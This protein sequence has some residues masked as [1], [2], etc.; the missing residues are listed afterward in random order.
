MTQKKLRADQLL[1]RLGEVANLDQAKRFIMAGQVYTDK[2]EPVLTAGQT[3]PKEAVL[4]IKKKEKKYVSRGGY[5]LEKAIEVFNL[6][7][8]DKIALDIGSSTGGFT[9][10]FLQNGAKLV[11][12]LDVGTNQLDWK[13]RSDDR[14]IVMEQTNFRFVEKES[15]T[16]GLPQLV[17][18][19][20]SFISLDLIFPNL[21]TII[22]E[23]GEVAAL[24]KPQFEAEKDQVG[25]NGIVSD[26]AVQQA[27]L[28][29]VIE[30]ARSNQ[31]TALQLTK[32]PIKGAGG[33][34]E[35]LL[36]LKKTNDLQGGL[37]D[38]LS[39]E[40]ALKEMI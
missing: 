35:F 24:V 37:S 29:K 14:V 17:S 19:D 15:F 7:I 16:A 12:A 11:Y 34:V 25:E 9:D 26:R 30:S 4:Y 6:S 27:V 22:A 31:F 20:V 33:N 1:V 21:K 8:Q 3:Y 40:G 38:S 2:E 36:H 23:R 28:E 13:L 18:I 39:I 5:K 32:S 10:A